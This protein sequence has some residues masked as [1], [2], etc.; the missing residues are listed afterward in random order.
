ML[1]RYTLQS[2]LSDANPAPTTHVGPTGKGGL[3]DL[4]FFGDY[5]Y[6]SSD[7][8][9]LKYSVAAMTAA[10]VVLSDPGAT[11][12]GLAFDT[13]GRLWICNYGVPGNLVRMSN[14]STGAID[15][16]ISGSNINNAE[17]LS[18][19]E[20]GSLWV[21]DNNEPTLYGYGSWQL[22]SSGSPTPVGQINLPTRQRRR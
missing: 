17:G 15:V 2:I 5:A 4:A 1:W 16:T 22:S 20:Y 12:V 6:V 8:G 21:G 9:I 3:Y 14:L 18:F 19:D 11:P 7:S 13:Q 10:P